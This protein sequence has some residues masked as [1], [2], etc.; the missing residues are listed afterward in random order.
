LL[1]ALHGSLFRRTAGR[2]QLG[3]AT[4]PPTFSL[5][6]LAYFTRLND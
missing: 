3:R 5:A 2:R 1:A 4:M 6:A